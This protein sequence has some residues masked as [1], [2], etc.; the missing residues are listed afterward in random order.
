MQVPA[1][2]G[3]LPRLGLGLRP[4]E[5]PQG[6]GSST[7]PTSSSTGS[8]PAGPAPTS[9][10]R[11]TTPRCSRPPRSTWSPTSGPTGW[12]ASPPRRTSR[13]PDGAHLEKAG[14]VRDGGSYNERM[15]SVACWNAVMDE[16][17]YM[18][19]KWNEFIAAVRTSR[20]PSGTGLRR[21][22]PCRLLRARR[23]EPGLK[24]QERS[25]RVGPPT[26][27]RRLWRLV[28]PPLLRP[29]PRGDLHCQLLEL[30]ELLDRARPSPRQLPRRVRPLHRPSARPL[31]H[32]PHL[33]VDPELLPDRLAHH[34][35][36]RL[37]HRLLPDLRD[38]H[39]GGAPRAVRSSARSRS[40]PRT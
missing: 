28:L 10:G 24:A 21:S 4:A 19:R 25:T 30:Y 32:V 34:P 6:Q 13:R 1:A 40:G 14:A 5:D 20:T 29:A 3:G 15:G 39:H 11:A 12:K 7:R 18:V 23:T 27:R 9:T 33:P 35:R 26:G 31:H 37:H 17:A 16:N 8:C 36:D 2:E 22:G 38:P